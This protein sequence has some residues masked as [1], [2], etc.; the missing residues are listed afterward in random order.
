MHNII[1]TAKFNNYW[2]DDFS[3]ITQLDNVSGL[4]LLTIIIDTVRYVGRAEREREREK[5]P[6]TVL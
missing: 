3:F 1:R 5:H 6:P 2:T 4:L